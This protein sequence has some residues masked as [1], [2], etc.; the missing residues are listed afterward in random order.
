MRPLPASQ[1]PWG[2]VVVSLLFAWAPRDLGSP[3]GKREK[4]GFKSSQGACIATWTRLE[5]GK[6]GSRWLGWWYFLRPQHEPQP[7]IQVRYLQVRAHTWDSF[8]A[9]G[10][11]KG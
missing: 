10:G 2:E 7:Q 5:E 1:R 8:W 11:I 3:R 6:Q 9:P 4:T